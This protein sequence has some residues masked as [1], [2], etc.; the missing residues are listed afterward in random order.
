MSLKSLIWGL[1]K[2][3]TSCSLPLSTGD[4]KT[5]D[6][7]IS[8]RNTEIHY[9]ERRWVVWGVS[10]PGLPSPPLSSQTR[11]TLAWGRGCTRQRN[12][13]K[14]EEEHSAQSQNQGSLSSS[15]LQHALCHP[16]AASGYGSGCSLAEKLHRWHSRAFAEQRCLCEGLGCSLGGMIS[17]RLTQ[18]RPGR[19]TR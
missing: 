14:V 6:E 2:S 19:V 7:T 10:V 9:R 4:H 17:H 15:D 12:P 11:L 18:R 5:E 1:W 3:D 8:S 16:Q 13:E